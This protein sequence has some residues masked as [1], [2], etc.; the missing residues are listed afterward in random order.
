MG[1]R[2]LAVVCCLWGSWPDPKWSE[3]YVYRLYRGVQRHLPL[4]HRFI[5]FADD[6]DRLKGAPFEVRK[7]RTPVWQGCLPKLYVY[8]PE[9]ELSGRVLLLDLD[10]V[11]TGD[12]AD[13][14]SYDGPFC[15]RAWFKG[16]DQGM[17]DKRDKRLL[18]GDMISFEV[19]ETSRW[20]WDRFKGNPELRATQTG[21]R[22][23]WYL[24][25]QLT[26]DK[27]PDVW[28]EIVPEQIVSWKNHMQNGKVPNG[29]RIV[30]CHGHPRP[31]EINQDW[32][33][34]HWV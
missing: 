25:D 5:C 3:E 32:V 9:A 10:N 33:R 18:D 29:A 8:S 24:R 26:G 14:A 2:N 1:Q 19:G 11:I 7:L 28:Q 20:L 30:S 27:T 4:D 13:I 23:R 15:V 34:E 16:W 31:H 12:L 17:R 21:G 22:E 6:P